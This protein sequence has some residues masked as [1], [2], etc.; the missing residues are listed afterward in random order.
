M[1]QLTEIIPSQP[2]S[3]PPAWC[4]Q[5]FQAATFRVA[6]PFCL[7]FGNGEI[8]F[9]EKIVRLLP[10]RRMVVFGSWNDKPVVAKLFF[11][12]KHAKRDRQ[13]DETGVLALDE[14]KIPTPALYAKLASKDGCVQALIF[15]RIEKATNLEEI[16]LNKNNSQEILPL[17]RQVIIEIATQHV[18]GVVQNDLHLNNFL[19]TKKKVYTLDGAQIKS[20]PRLLPKDKSMENLALFLSQL[21]VGMEDCQEKLF[22][23]YAKSRGWLLKPTDI[24]ALFLLIKEWNAK[25]WQRY[26]K[27]IFRSCT[28]FATFKHRLH[29]GMYNR[30]YLGSDLEKFM[31]N[32]EN[33]FHDKSAVILKAGRSTTVI[34]VLLDN[35]ILVIKRYNLKNTWHRLRRCLRKTRAAVSWRLAHKLRLFGVATAIPVAY[36]ENTFFG[37]R[38]KSYLVTEYVSTEHIGQYFIQHQHEE[39]KTDAMIVQVTA[40]LKNL[41]K[42]DM[43]HGDLKMTNILINQKE[44]PVLIDLDG[45]VEHAVL[46]GL[47]RAWHKEIKR[48]LRNFKELPTVIAKFEETLCTD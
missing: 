22:R 40:L 35:K 45:A 23:H 14:N 31:Q 20:F 44:Q 32:P 11:D 46:S 29:H 3:E 30:Q 18:L 16:W 1:E 28:D 15:K 4:M 8:F 37:L 19:V 2:I 34:K 9:A 42:L 24:A 39:K 48:F 26:E 17:L 21:G 36:I 27:K 38:G 43:T 47:K 10:K 41:A 5:D 33:I 12:V 6:V 25:R 7:Q 13:R